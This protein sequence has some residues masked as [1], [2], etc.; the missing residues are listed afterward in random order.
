MSNRL[1]PFDWRAP[2]LAGLLCYEPLA[3]SSRGR[4]PTLSEICRKLRE[5]PLGVTLIVGMLLL[6]A[7]HLLVEEGEHRWQ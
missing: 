4:L 7:H 5:H 3:L 6:L 1:P 2:L